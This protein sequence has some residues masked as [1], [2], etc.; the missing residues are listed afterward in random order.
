[1][2][3]IV[4]AEQ[5]MH[6]IPL[7]LPLQR[8]Q[9]LLAVRDQQHPARRGIETL[10]VEQLAHDAP[11]SIHAVSISRLAIMSAVRDLR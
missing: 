10:F 3:T 6:T 1:V 7:V 5:S 9:P 4:D 8:A 2:L 11:Q